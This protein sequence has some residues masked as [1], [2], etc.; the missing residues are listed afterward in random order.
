M[1]F[2]SQN[3]YTRNKGKFNV[4]GFRKGKAPRKIIES[5]YGSDVFYEDA[6]N[7]L[8]NDAYPKALSDLNLTPIARPQVE[9]DKLEKDKDFSARI[10]VEVRPD[11]EVKDYKGVK[12]E[13][14]DR[15]VTDEDMEKEM[16]NLRMKNSRMIA[17]D[18]PAANGD[19][20]LLD[21]AGFVGDE[22][23]EGGTAERQVLK[24]GSGTFIPG[25]EEQLAH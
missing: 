12:I 7:E 19:S 10:S 17:V 2:R 25:F 8:F 22:Q 6:I 3:A 5:H 4:D 14:V 11:F 24:L 23:F 21:Y 16:E 9:F 18:R 20:V 15:E 1:L 13:K